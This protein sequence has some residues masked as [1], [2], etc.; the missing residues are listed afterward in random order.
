M[1]L[2]AQMF[3]SGFYC[4]VII[5]IIITLFILVKTGQLIKI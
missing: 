3:Y 4:N 1:Y 5:I 2:D